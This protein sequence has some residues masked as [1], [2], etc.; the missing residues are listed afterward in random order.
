MRLWSAMEALTADPFVGLTAGR[1]VELDFM[2]VLGPTFA[3]SPNLRAG[4][5]IVAHVLPHLLPHA[6]VELVPD[7]LSYESPGTERHGIDSMFATVLTLARVCTR[8]PDLRVVSVRHQARRPSTTAPYVELF[9]VEPAF[10]AARSELRFS[11]RDLELRFGGHEPTAHTLLVALAPQAVRPENP[12]FA[13]E[14]LNALRHLLPLEESALEALARERGTS[15][16]TLQ[17]QLAAHGLRFRDLVEEA[18]RQL[19]RDL[20]DSG[21]SP[22]EIARALGYSDPASLARA[23]RRWQRSEKA[24]RRPGP[25]RRGVATSTASL[26]PTNGS[27]SRTTSGSPA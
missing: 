25:D 6:R 18:R 23:R 5:G 10:E 19:C 15:T 9:G 26:H 22:L 20:V 4:L 12:T 3:T 27:S 7:G 2:G 13:R 1:R 17:R 21:R 14:V 11:D 16:R 24:E 8:T